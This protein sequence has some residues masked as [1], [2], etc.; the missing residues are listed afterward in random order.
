MTVDELL[1]KL[2]AEFSRLSGRIPELYQT[3]GEYCYKY[4][5]AGENHEARRQLNAI[6]DRRAAIGL[7]DEKIREE[8]AR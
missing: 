6:R 4:E 7:L 5:S 1:A 2:D 3:L 8:R